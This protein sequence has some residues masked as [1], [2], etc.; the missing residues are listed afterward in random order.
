MHAAQVRINLPTLTD[1][2]KQVMSIPSEAITLVGSFN[3]VSWM[4]PEYKTIQVELW[5]RV[6]FFLD[7][8]SRFFALLRHEW[9]SHFNL[10]SHLRNITSTLL[11]RI[12]SFLF[13]HAE[14][15]FSLYLL[16]DERKPPIVDQLN[17]NMFSFFSNFN[18]N[19]VYYPSIPDNYIKF[20]SIMR[21][22]SAF[23]RSEGILFFRVYFPLM[24]SGFLHIITSG[25]VPRVI[26]A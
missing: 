12:S 19:I 15:Y 25:S 4:Q 6:Y 10:G 14:R 9:F 20:P 8:S 21:D 22:F 17:L 18:K 1:V 2:D 3:L 23:V 11:L 16:R 7:V 26:K 13:H 24:N 5:P